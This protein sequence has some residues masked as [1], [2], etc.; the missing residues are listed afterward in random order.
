MNHPHWNRRDVLRHGAGLTGFALLPQL[1]AAQGFAA[2]AAAFTDYRALVCV[3]LFGGNDSLNIVVPRSTPEYVV[4]AQSRQ[5][6]ALVMDVL[7][8]IATVSSD[9]ALYGVHPSMLGF[10]DL[11]DR[12]RVASVANV[13]T[14]LQPLTKQQVL[15]GSGRLPP[16]LF[17]HNDQQDQWQYLAGNTALRTGWAGRVADELQA[18]MSS[19]A[20]N[21]NISL[22]GSNA[23]QSGVNGGAYAVGPEGA[24]VYA[25][26]TPTL[27]FAA[28][29]RQVFERL[30]GASHV[31]A[32]TRAFAQVHQRA[33]DNADRVNTALAGA[34]PLQSVFPATSLGAQ[35]KEVARLIAV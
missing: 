6:L 10:G 27:P 12:G 11:F 1:C 26:L 15:D 33:L 18:P 8:P 35:L 23:L 4:Y 25:A 21:L 19:D 20:L 3:F 7:R 30:L 2:G 34:A 22:F 29:R 9:G 28:Q 32:I 13:G 5:N 14:L 31:S 24:P 17:S 16:Q